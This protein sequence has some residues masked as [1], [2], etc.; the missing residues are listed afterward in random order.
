MTQKSL[1]LLAILV[2]ATGC[3]KPSYGYGGGGGGPGEVRTLSA[4]REE[5]R[6]WRGSR[7]RAQ[8]SYPA[9]PAPAATS[10]DKESDFSPQSGSVSS[11]PVAKAMPRRGGPAA[12]TPGAPA[13]DTPADGQTAGKD[14]D[15][16]GSGGPRVASDEK[17][18]QTRLIIYRGTLILQVIQL[19]DSMEAAQK[20]ALDMGAY[21]QARANNQLTF[22]VPVEKFQLLLKALESIGEVASKSIHADDVTQQ[23]YD[24]EVRLKA[25]ET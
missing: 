23:N 10:S 19:N 2:L 22:R 14:E 12:S 17:L 18:P 1:P 3:T 7:Y 9:S 21:L 16:Q 5:G 25:A 11:E 24:I 20:L 13:V 8:R 6:S 15:G 4:E